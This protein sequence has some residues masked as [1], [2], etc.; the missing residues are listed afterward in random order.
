MKEVIGV[1]LKEFGK[2]FAQLRI[3]NGY[4]SQRKL[5]D[6]A[7]ISN[8]TIARIEDGS[9][10]PSPETLKKVA[11]CLKTISFNELMEHAGYRDYEET[12]YDVND[13]DYVLNRD[14]YRVKYEDPE[15]RETKETPSQDGTEKEFFNDLDLSDEELRNKYR[16]MVDGRELTDK[17]WKKL[18]AIVRLERQLDED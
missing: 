8:G 10:Q 4:M 3:D 17:E 16:I 13:P 1:D 11:K 6:A 14:K 5:A 12:V 18:L 2:F 7:G 9:Q 15:T